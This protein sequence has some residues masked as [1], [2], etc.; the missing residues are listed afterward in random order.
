LHGRRQLSPEA[1]DRVLAAQFLTVGDLAPMI[2]RAEATPAE[3]EGGLFPLVSHSTAMFEPYIRTSAVQSMV[4]FP[5]SALEP[6]QP[7]ALSSRR[8]WQRFVAVRISAADAAAMDPVVQP[9][10]TVLIDRHYNSL[11][12]PGP[13]RVNIYAVRLDSRLVLRYVDFQHSRLVLRPHSVA[14]PVVLLEIGLDEA[15]N[16]LV[17]GRVTLIQNEY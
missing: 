8:A 11:R 17:V 2:A 15:P 1:L 9:Q 6:Y 16:D 10:A 12:P 13:E 5:P 7:R 3:G 4:R 14:A